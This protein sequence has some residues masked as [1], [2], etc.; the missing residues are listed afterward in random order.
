MLI[1]GNDVINL[2]VQTTK[3]NFK[4]DVN[5]EAKIF[6]IEIAFAKPAVK[7]ETFECNLLQKLKVMVLERELE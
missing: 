5:Y 3:V 6:R 7:C 1:A 4:C 2:H